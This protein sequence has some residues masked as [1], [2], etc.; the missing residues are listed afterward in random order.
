[1]QT[2]IMARKPHLI[3]FA[4]SIFDISAY[5]AG[6]SVVIDLVRKNITAGRLFG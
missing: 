4:D 1:M 3:L 6:A 5:T 2:I